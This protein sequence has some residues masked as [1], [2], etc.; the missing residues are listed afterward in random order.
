[1]A[2]TASPTFAQDTHLLLVTGVPG[3]PE[4]EQQFGTWG[5]AIHD[6]AR[7]LQVADANVVYLADKPDTD[8]KRI[9]GRSTREGI[10]KAIAQIASRT[11]PNDDVFVVLIGH[12]TSDGKSGA[13]NVSGPDLTPDDLNKAFAAFPT[14]R[15]VVV[16]TTA[17]SGVFLS[18]LAGPGRVIVTATKTGGERNDTRFPAYFVEALEGETPDRDR[19]GRVSILEAFEYARAKVTEVYQQEGHIL[20]EHATLDDG[21][22]GKFAA[23]LFLAPPLSRT[24]AVQS[25]DPK[26]RA[27]LEEREALE[28]QVADLRLRKDS[29]DAAR[30]EA[31]LEKLVTDL[32]LKAR[33]IRELEVKK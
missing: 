13:F 15:I 14:Q 12:G 8:A 32:A 26:L 23:T 27:L 30:Y 4:H 24:A 1:V 29:M 3:D 21:N 17:S 2:A 10:T 9:R 11:R 25:A 31:E 22:E 33:A 18:P 5:Q 16:N 7:R 6:A 20:T 19:N 28:R